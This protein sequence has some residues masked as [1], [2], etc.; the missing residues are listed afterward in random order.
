MVTAA[1]PR[2]QAPSGWH[3]SG[4][5][6]GH[7]PATRSG[8]H[9]PHLQLPAGMSPVSLP[10][11]GAGPVTNSKGHAVCR[12][13]PWNA[14]RPPP[15][16]SLLGLGPGLAVTVELCARSR[17]TS[18]LH[19]PCAVQLPW[20][21]RQLETVSLRAHQEADRSRKP[22]LGS[23]LLPRTSLR[24]QARSESH[25]NRSASLLSV[26]HCHLTFAGHVK[27]MVFLLRDYTPT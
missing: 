4:L 16:G 8:R 6:L 24:E 27:V 7:S 26:K 2:H 11:C 1:V 3:S 18:E 5:H 23:P 14:H 10:V 20:M 17:V 9:L 12:P 25:A 19:G 21:W 15:P 13:W 22:A